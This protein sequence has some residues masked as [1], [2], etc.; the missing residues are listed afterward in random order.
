MQARKSKAE[1]RIEG[2]MAILLCHDMSL[3]RWQRCEIAR[4]L[5]EKYPANAEEMA[6]RPYKLSDGSLSW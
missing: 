5:V 1:K 2:I 3:S 6:N 4:Y